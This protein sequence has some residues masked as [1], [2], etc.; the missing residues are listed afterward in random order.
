MYGLAFVGMKYEKKKP[1]KEIL[2]SILLMCQK[3]KLDFFFI[4]PNQIFINEE[5]TKI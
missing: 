1:I 4:Y 2:S 3:C 5:R